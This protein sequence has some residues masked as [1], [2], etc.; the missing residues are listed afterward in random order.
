MRVI[1]TYSPPAFVQYITT[2]IC[3]VTAML[4]PSTMTHAVSQIQ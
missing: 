4:G 1:Y 2:S 3:H